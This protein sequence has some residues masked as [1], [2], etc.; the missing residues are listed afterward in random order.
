VRHKAAGRAGSAGG[1][2]RSRRSRWQQAERWR[3]E[4]G[5]QRGSAEKSSRE[6]SIYIAEA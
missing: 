6:K 1:E 3:G 2:R 4:A 5:R